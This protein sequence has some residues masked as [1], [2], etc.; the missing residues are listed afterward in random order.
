MVGKDGNTKSGVNSAPSAV[1]LS[2]RMVSLAVKKVIIK[3]L[4]GGVNIIFARIA[5]K[6]SLQVFQ[7][8]QGFPIYLYGIAKNVGIKLTT[9]VSSRSRV[10]EQITH[11]GTQKTPIIVNGVA[12]N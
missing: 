1:G 5:Q 8:S 10:S 6:I 12:E 2:I 7:K 3:I 4:F 9:E 11:K